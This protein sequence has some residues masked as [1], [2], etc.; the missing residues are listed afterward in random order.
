VA[1]KADHAALR[2]AWCGTDN[3]EPANALARATAAVTTVPTATT[4]GTTITAFSGG[5]Q[6]AYPMQNPTKLPMAEL[7]TNTRQR[8]RSKKPDSAAERATQVNGSHA[9]SSRP[10]TMIV[11][12]QPRLAERKLS[13]T[14]PACFVLV[15]FDQLP[16]SSRS[17]QM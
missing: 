6:I 16:T 1:I 10:G 14:R 8:S 15:A 12:S 7:R 2:S 11:G 9:G 4:I 17:L 5:G 13:V 3:L